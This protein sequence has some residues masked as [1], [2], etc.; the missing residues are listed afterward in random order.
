MSDDINEGQRLSSF[1]P[2][3]L[4]IRGW[5][6]NDLASMLGIPK[7]VVSKIINAKQAP[8]FQQIQEMSIAFDIPVDELIEMRLRDE[9]A[10]VGAQDNR[11]DRL[12][13]IELYKRLPISEI[14][15]RGWA[16]V[17][18]R[19]DAKEM[20]RVFAPMLADK[21][22]A[23]GLARKSVSGESFSRIQEAWVLHLFQIASRMP[24]SGK[25]K[26][27]CID[28][29][30]ADAREVMNSGS[31]FRE[32]FEI[33]SR[34]GI[35]LVF[36]ECKR[37]KIDGFCMWLNEESPVIGMSLRFDREDYFWFT[38]FHEL[39][40]VK[41][42]YGAD[43][44]VDCDLNFSI[45]LNRLE[46]NAN[47]LAQS[48]CVDPTLMEQL[49]GES[50]GRFTDK[51]VR[52]FA[53]E[54]GLNVSVLAGQVRHRFNRYNILSKLIKEVRSDVAEVAHAI[55]GWGWKR[56]SNMT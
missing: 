42:G 11:A 51:A 34:S 53:L 2:E 30:I 9:A 50:N 37:S 1:I 54:H 24:V 43:V 6:Q 5:T 21:N 22:K 19:T 47:A 16:T 12:K 27:E 18:D 52:D 26:P 29:V 17:L 45:G 7:S 49:V 15:D 25:F 13:L 36:I 10:Q 31:G 56:I 40:H 38:L 23:H 39:A 8:T 46:E 4:S 55:D 14:L 3:A 33:L 48:V 35:R 41:Q 20:V 28:R 32:L 44:G